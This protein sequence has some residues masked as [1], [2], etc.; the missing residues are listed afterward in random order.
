MIKFDNFAPDRRGVIA[1]LAFTGLLGS[2]AADAS[3]ATIPFARV[4]PGGI[5]WPTAADWNTLGETVG[6]RLS[7][8]TLPV[9]AQAE[10]AKLLANPFYIRDQAGLTQSS[11][12]IDGWQSAP[13]AYVVRVRNAADVAAA[14]TFAARHRLR[15]VVKGGGHSYLGGSNAADSLLVWTR[16]METIELHHAF[17][18][19]GSASTG[20]PAVSVGAGAIWHDVY[21]AVTTR[22]GRYVQ[23]GGC[24]T[25]GVAGLVQGGGFG[26]FSKTFGI[27]A[28]HLLEAEIVT[29]D[30]QVCTVNAERDP[31]LFW[32]LK[33]GGGGTWGVVTRLTL[34][35]HELP[36]T[37]GLVHWNLKAT[38]DD[39]FRNLLARFVDLYADHLFNPHWGE[40]VG[41][42]HGNRI[43]VLMLFQG[44]DEAAA[45]TAWR[46]LTEHVDA[47]PHDYVVEEPLII[48]AFPAN[49]FWDG[50][51]VAQHLPGV[52]VVD[53]RPDAK[54]GN[55]WWAGNTEEVGAF[56]HGYES[57]WLPASLLDQGQRAQL[58]D[59]WFAASRL[60]SVT[61]H[62][63]KGLAGAPT[64]AIAASR[65]TAMNP[66][67]LDA[68]ALAIVAMDGPSAYDGLPAPDLV[69]A[70]GNLAQ[71]RAAMAA[72]RK[73]A[74]D[75]GSY[76]SE[77]N[78]ALVDWRTACWGR[79]AARLDAVKA[80]YDPDGLFVLHHGIGSELWGS[81][82]FRRVV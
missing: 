22:G 46:D 31:D 52:L 62:F 48:G 18:P 79:H 45:R 9:L 73:V 42:R 82:G 6:G 66:Q 30:G 56:W 14:V 71:I 77:S 63:N 67:V 32:A 80:R 12:R 20:V 68:F 57:A 72:L 29:A 55:W 21:N 5:G 11:G 54:P 26:S 34:Q 19:A 16:D 60:W 17:I 7:P 47:R 78:F 13:S 44:L 50:A 25:V 39:A 35:T 33:G 59:A 81:D 4:R 3:A 51:F 49:R 27:A 8:V 64:A 28:A 53:D 40:Q 41:L 70:R 36:A 37:F 43:E 23:G 15:L 10:A 65:E 38:S 1:G 74:P 69:E 76:L 24:T 2:A 61:L 75:A 58:V